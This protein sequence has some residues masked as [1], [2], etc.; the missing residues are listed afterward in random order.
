MLNPV[1]ASSRLLGG[2]PKGTTIISSMT[3][4]SDL[5]VVVENLGN[6]EDNLDPFWKVDMATGSVS[7]FSPQEYDDPASIISG[8]GF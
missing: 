4:G 5:L 3:Y 6:D 1:Q 2:L 8:L 7:D